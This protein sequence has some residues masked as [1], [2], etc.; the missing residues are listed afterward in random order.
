MLIREAGPSLLKCNFCF[1][2]ASNS[3][4]IPAE[5]IVNLF[6]ALWNTRL[7]TAP[8]N[9]SVDK[10]NVSDSLYI[11]STRSILIESVAYFLPSHSLFCGCFVENP[12]ANIKQ[13][14]QCVL[15]RH[16]LYIFWPTDIFNLR[17]YLSFLNIPSVMWL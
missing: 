12:I 15:V 2:I 1:Y 14:A 4:I 10:E 11:S 8:P 13:H 16:I 6:S 17:S 7:F 9:A 3:G 5:R